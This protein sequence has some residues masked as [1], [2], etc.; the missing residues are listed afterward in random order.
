MDAAGVGTPQQEDYARGVKEQHEERQDWP[1]EL[2]WEIP[3]ELLHSHAVACQPLLREVDSW[4]LVR[5]DRIAWLSY[6]LPIVRI[7]GGEF[8]GRTA[9]QSDQRPQR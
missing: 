2:R 1:K 5:V 4:R 3:R 9:R 7:R 8:D 6:N